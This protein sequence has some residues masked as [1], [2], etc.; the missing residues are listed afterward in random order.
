MRKR[1][2]LLLSSI[3]LLSILVTA[4]CDKKD[5]VSATNKEKIEN[6]KLPQAKDSNVNLSLYFDS[7]QDDKK[8]EIAKE[9]RLLEKD[10]LV[11][12]LIMQE[13]IKGPSIES[14]LSPILPKDTRLL[15]FSIKDSIAYVNLSNDVKVPMSKT[16]EEAC[17]KSIAASLTQLSSIKKI[18]ILIQNKDA[19]TLGGSYN[20]AKPF[21]KDDID[22]LQK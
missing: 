12:E 16:K 4:G 9:V 5:V 3:L 2:G 6:L 17:L 18:K 14:K 10:E 15:S 13:L 20:I 7:S 19:D 21:G 22:G 1:I 11:G 8:A